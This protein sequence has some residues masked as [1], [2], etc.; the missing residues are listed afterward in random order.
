M[1]GKIV[2]L[3]DTNFD[4]EVKQ[5]NW[6]VDFYA[7]WCGPCKMM[8]PHFEK[9][10]E[11]IKGVKFGKVDVDGNQNTAAKFGVMSIPTTILLKDGQPVDVHTGA[12]KLE[13]IKKKI[14]GNF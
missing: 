2:E 5:G 9:A 8:A 11:E 3:T 10:S 4:K 13:D 12:L 14:K 6:I 7:D 1:T